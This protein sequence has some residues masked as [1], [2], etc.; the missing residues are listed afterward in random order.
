MRSKMRLPKK[1]WDVL[2]RAEGK[3]PRPCNRACPMR[4]LNGGVCP[5][6]AICP[7][8]LATGECGHPSGK[9]PHA[10]WLAERIGEGEVIEWSQE[11]KHKNARARAT[12]EN[13]GGK[14]A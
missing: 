1:V 12:A 13:I 2:T 10:R 5:P 14:H 3:L 6:C 4:A 8:R 11:K 7:Y 9:C